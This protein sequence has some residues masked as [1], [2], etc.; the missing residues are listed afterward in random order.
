MAIVMGQEPYRDLG[1]TKLCAN[2][3]ERKNNNKKKT[4]LEV[5]CSSYFHSSFH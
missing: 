5:L 3:E 1:I 2:F 4:T